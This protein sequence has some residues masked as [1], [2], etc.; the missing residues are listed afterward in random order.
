[1]AENLYTINGLHVECGL[2]RDSV[3]EYLQDVEPRKVEGKREYYAVRQL[4]TAFHEVNESR[5]DPVGE[6]ARLNRLRADKVE[7]ENKK[8]AAELV[9]VNDAVQLIG[10]YI[11]ACV[12][13]LTEL[14][15]R[16]GPL[17]IGC[18]SI[19][20]ITLKLEEVICECIEEISEICPS[21]DHQRSANSVESASRRALRTRQ[22]LPSR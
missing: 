8:L 14:P 10:G 9:D 19:N 12:T 17:L 2:A 20:Q 13:K 1:M 6:L 15:T 5:Q 21:D 22:G 11:S 3:R 18:K 4:F 7:I 16:A